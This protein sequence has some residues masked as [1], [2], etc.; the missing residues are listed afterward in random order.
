MVSH[1]YQS[2]QIQ[3]LIE[4]ADAAPS[5]FFN[6][7]SD[8]MPV[9]PE[10]VGRA[11]YIDMISQLY[12][13]EIFTISICARLVRELPD[14]QAIRFLCTQMNEEARHAEAYAAYIRKLGDI[15]PMNEKLEKIFQKAL[16][17][18]GSPYALILGLNVVL[19]GE[20]LNQQRKRIDTLPCPL[21]KAI[22]LQIIQDEAR[23]SGFGHLYLQDKLPTLSPEEKS[24]MAQ[25]IG[26]LW[27]EWKEANENRY[28]QDGYELLRTTQQELD[29]R[30]EVQKRALKHLGLSA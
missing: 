14:F 3:K 21:F 10:G 26:L 7:P 18:K 6:P 5:I 25:W 22:N 20:A 28:L 12:H 24:E 19:E 16:D 1:I 4:K 29:T 30:L 17:W 13:A 2:E 15:A 11:D 9:I 23:H 8:Q 27:N